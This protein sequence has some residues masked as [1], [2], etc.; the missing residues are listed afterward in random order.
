MGV[1]FC[2]VGWLRAGPP[3]TLVSG[4]SCHPVLTYLSHS[5]LDLLHWG[6]LVD[7][8]TELSKHLVVPNAQV[9]SPS[10]PSTW[11]SLMCR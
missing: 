2:G 9:T 7:S 3:Q 6:S 11:W 8:R 1:V 4:Q 5:T 10:C